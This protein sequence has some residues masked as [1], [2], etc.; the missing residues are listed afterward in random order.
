LKRTSSRR[1]F[2][3]DL[4]KVLGSSTPA[5][6]AKNS[7]DGSH[8]PFSARAATRAGKFSSSRFRTSMMD[9]EPVESALIAHNEKGHHEVTK[10]A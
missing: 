8:T 2:V 1:I 10:P 4:K 7:K 5:A 9:L 6:F 3:V